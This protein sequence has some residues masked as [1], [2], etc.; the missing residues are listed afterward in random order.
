LD[1][2]DPENLVLPLF[3]SF[4]D[5]NRAVLRYSNPDLDKLGQM[6]EVERSWTERI[7]LFRRI[8]QLLNEDMPAIPLYSRRHR[9]ALQPY[10]RGVRT[11]PLGF[12]TFNAAEVWL[13]K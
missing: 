9:L 6:A 2:P 11:P 8:E 10:V 7:A 12:F 1:F 5:L 3:Y 4:S 13:D